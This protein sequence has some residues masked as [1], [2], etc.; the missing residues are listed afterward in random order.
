MADQS[1]QNRGQEQ[2]PQTNPLLFSEDV[3][4]N[5]L[6]CIL[7]NNNNYYSAGNLLKPELFRNGKN[8]KLFK[9]MQDGF[10][11]GKVVDT[12][13]LATETMQKPDETA[14]SPQDIMTLFGGYVS[15]VLFQQN[16]EYL[17]ELARRRMFWRLGS[18]LMR[19]G[20]DMSYSA[21]NA[22]KEIAKAIESEESDNKGVMTM[23]EANALLM[24]KVADN[25]SGKSDSFLQTG[26]AV[27][28]ESGGFQLADFD[29]IAADSSAGKTSLATRIMENMARHGH[30]CMSY[31]MEMMA[32]QLAARINSPKANIPSNIIQ[33]KDLTEYQYHDLQHAIADT[34]NLP[35]YFDDNSTSS[36]DAILASIRL[37]ARKLGI[38]CFM[39]DYLQ[40][41]PAVG[42]V[43]DQEKFLGELS[44][45]FKN[46]AKELNVN[47][48]VLS[49]LARNNMDPR[50]TLARVR[51]SGQIVEAADTVL[52]IWRPSMYGKTSYKNSHASVLNTAEIIIGKGRNIGTGS[53]I[54]HFDP[55]TTNFY[56]ASPEERERWKKGGTET[57]PPASEQKD[58]DPLPDPLPAPKEPTEQQLPF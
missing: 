41:L 55:T 29:V 37:N 26:F 50:P 20:T 56:D 17:R 31:S 8:A 53:F 49:Q 47:I 30:P 5:V 6:T 16:L 45:R 32:W 34:D 35:I 4:R 14:Y 3:E 15:D 36:A 7:N 22:M 25:H 44:R 9:M 57:P 54:V 2:A 28:D 39:I 33:Y 24:Q 1:K 40:I 52:L 27:L 38:K 58:D 42:M 23:R 19:I 46:L 18:Q 21:D 48:T 43:R 13:Y 51:A 10:S 11:K 12:L